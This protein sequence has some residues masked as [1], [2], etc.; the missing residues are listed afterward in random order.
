MNRVART[1]KS[2]LL[3]YI[4]YKLEIISKY[5]DNVFAIRKIY[6]CKKKCQILNL[7][8]NYPH[9]PRALGN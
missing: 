8:F 2:R 6:I 4:S 7:G 9:I 1:L 3:F 5:G